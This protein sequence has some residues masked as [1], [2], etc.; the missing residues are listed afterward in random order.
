[1]LEFIFGTDPVVVTSNELVSVIEYFYEEDGDPYGDPFMTTVQSVTQFRNS[2]SFMTGTINGNFINRNVTIV[3]TLKKT[4]TNQLLIHNKGG[5]IVKTVVINTKQVEDYQLLVMNISYDEFYTIRHP[6]NK[7]FGLLIYGLPHEYIGYGYPVAMSFSKS[8]TSVDDIWCFD[9]IDMSH[10]KYCDK[11]TKCSSRDQVCFVQS[12]MRSLDVKLYRS[13]CIDKK[14]CNSY[15]Q[16]SCVTCCNDSF[17]NTQGCGDNGIHDIQ[18]RGPMCFDCNHRGEKDS[19]R[20]LQFCA[21]DE[22]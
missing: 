2:Y 14:G 21:P 15:G 20:T 6:D 9:C 11:V 1:M 8:D 12:Y 7:E 18:N 5:Q 3:I 22:V 16:S 19:C 13:G 10:L 4:Y 17:C